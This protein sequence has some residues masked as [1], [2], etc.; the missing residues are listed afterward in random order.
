MSK[1][2]ILKLKFFENYD[3]TII[4]GFL[5]EFWPV[6]VAISNFSRMVNGVWTKNVKSTAIKGKD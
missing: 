3:V 1:E 6:I 5:R 4:T 2:N